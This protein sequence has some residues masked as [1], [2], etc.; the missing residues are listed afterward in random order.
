MDAI[1]QVGDIG[2][3]IESIHFGA[4]DECHGASE[5]FGAGLGAGE[6][7][8]FLA[9]TYGPDGAFGG[10]VVDGDAAIVEKQAERVPAAEGIAKGLGEIAF[11]R[12]SGELRLSPGMQGLEP[13]FAQ[14]LTHVPTD[15]GRL[16]GDLALDVIE[17]PDTLKRL[18][19]YF[20]FLGRPDVVKIASP[21]GKAGC[22]PETWIPIR[23]R[24]VELRIAFVGVGLENAVCVAK[25]V[26][27][28]LRIPVGRIAI[29]DPGR[30]GTGPGALIT[31]I[32][33]D[34]A[35]LDAFACPSSE[36]SA[37]LAA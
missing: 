8:V 12:D 13:G 28:V 27:D 20:G 6:Q 14:L 23:V 36:H 25:L 10:I 35:L 1:E 18:V 33:P 31:D 26:L 32:C 24:F 2:L 19:C 37:Q 16:T 9:E 11:A 34:P 22:F 17:L 4:F 30:R 21:M 5:G 3:R 29:D 15:I 7:P